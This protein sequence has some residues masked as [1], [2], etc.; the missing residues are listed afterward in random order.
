MSFLNISLP[1]PK[2]IT[3]Q[4]QP[5]LAGVSSGVVFNPWKHHLKFL[6]A[7]LLQSVEK[8]DALIRNH[9]LTIGNNV[10]DLYCGNLSPSYISQYILEE[11]NVKAVNNYTDYCQW[12]NEQ[13]YEILVLEDD[14][15]WTLLIGEEP[16]YIHIHP[17]RN[18][19]RTLRIKALTLKSAVWLAYEVLKNQSNID[20]DVVNAVRVERLKASPIRSFSEN[21]PLSRLLRLLLRFE[22]G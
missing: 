3:E 12:I 11:L 13:G 17:A 7:I 2:S 19:L 14:S 15:T 21:A 22:F 1:I 4:W 5:Y 20:L 8:G 16:H 9:I 6:Q 10:T 18:S